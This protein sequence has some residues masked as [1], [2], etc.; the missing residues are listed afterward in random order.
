MGYD[1]EIT[2]HP[3]FS[4]RAGPGISTDEW[5][6]LI[7]NDPE[8]EPEFDRRTGTASLDTAVWNT[9]NSSKQDDLPRLWHVNGR[10]STKYPEEPL[11]VKLVRIA[12]I[13]KAD[14][15]G[16]NC[17]IYDLDAA[18]TLV[19][20]E[21]GPSN[22]P[23]PHSTEP[24]KQAQTTAQQQTPTVPSAALASL[25]GVGALSCQKFLD[26]VQADPGAI[27]IFYQW[28]LGC[29]TMMNLNLSAMQKPLINFVLDDSRV[30]EDQAFLR[31]FALAHKDKVF[32]AAALALVNFHTLRVGASLKTAS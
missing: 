22:A 15:V 8:L 1:V 21:G 12:R 17:E 32:S 6:I 28:Y 4:R 18:D 2:R 19:Q 14:V 24:V 27:R 26:T 10:I 20:Y 23:K 7:E 16:D 31:T 5:R 9:G 30:I 3:L 29:L 11:I 25:Y 13:L